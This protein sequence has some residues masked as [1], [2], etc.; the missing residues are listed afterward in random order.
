VLRVL[1]H[2]LLVLTL[3]APPAWSGPQ[4]A[5]SA[6]VHCPCCTPGSCDGCACASD[7]DTAP[8]PAPLR[9]EI[10]RQLLAIVPGL[11]QVPANAPCPVAPVSC[12]ARRAST[13]SVRL[14]A[15]LCR[16]LT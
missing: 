15:V 14:Q 7:V 5:D 12:E 4:C 6:D 11:M 16:W 13:S 9:V 3:A 10:P 8:K 1:I 2:I